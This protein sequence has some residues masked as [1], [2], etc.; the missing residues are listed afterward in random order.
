MM[1]EAGSAF[2]A[3]A[4]RIGNHPF[5]EFTGLMNEYINACRAA[6]EAGIDFSDC[7]T[8]SGL[9][10]PMKDYQIDYVNEKLECIF[11]GRCVLKPNAGVEGHGVAVSLSNELLGSVTTNKEKP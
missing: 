10:L 4:V 2:Y 3:A 1:S 11:T 6:H 7:S 9:D 5:I 8:H